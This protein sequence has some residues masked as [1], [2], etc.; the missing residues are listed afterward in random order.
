MCIVCIKLVQSKLVQYRL[1]VHCT[2]QGEECCIGEPQSNK[3]ITPLMNKWLKPA[4]FIQAFL[5]F[6]FLSFF[7]TQTSNSRYS[8]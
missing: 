1:G 6:S 5:F 8:E 4:A 3:Q 7:R 2:A